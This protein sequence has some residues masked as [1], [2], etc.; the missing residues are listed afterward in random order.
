MVPQG[1]SAD[2]IAAVENFSREDLDGFAAL[3]QE[4]AQVAIREGRFEKSLIP[5]VDEDGNE[6]PVRTVGTLL[7]KG[8]SIAAGYWN[9][10]EQTKNT[11]LGE[12]INTHDKFLVD[13]DGYYWYAG[14]TDDMMKVGGQ[15][16]WPTDVEAILQQHPA[17]LESG[18]AGIAALT[19]CAVLLGTGIGALSNAIGVL[20]RRVETMVAVSNFVLLPLTFLTGLLGVNLGGIPYAAEPWAFWAFCAMLTGATALTLWLALR[21]LR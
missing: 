21:L 7:I 9:K 17:V 19:V 3:S 12:W 5:V 1:I 13:E 6:V 18:V 15:A 10:H 20:S 14:R 11:F 8:E 16:V 2:L 4:R